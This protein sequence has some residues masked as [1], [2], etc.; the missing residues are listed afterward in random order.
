MLVH[1]KGVYDRPDE[2]MTSGMKPYNRHVSM[3]HVREARQMQL[4]RDGDRLGRTTAMLGDD[5]LAA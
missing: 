4:V 5:D 1:M 3:G 2:S